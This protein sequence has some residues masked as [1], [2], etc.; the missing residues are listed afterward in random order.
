VRKKERREPDRVEAYV[1]KKKVQG[2]VERKKLQ[3]A[4]ADLRQKGGKFQRRGRGNLLFIGKKRGTQRIIGGGEEH[5]G[6]SQCNASREKRKKGRSERNEKAWNFPS[7][8]NPPYN[9]GTW[10]GCS[11]RELPVY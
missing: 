2:K 1:E 8:I 11:E 6:R 4:S 5:M 7:W 3:G 10:K 9:S